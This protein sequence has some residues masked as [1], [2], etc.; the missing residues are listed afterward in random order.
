MK[1]GSAWQVENT[2]TAN[3]RT[4]MYGEEKRENRL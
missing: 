3:T 4:E 1:D 2:T